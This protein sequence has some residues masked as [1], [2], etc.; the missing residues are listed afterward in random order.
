MSKTY[1]TNMTYRTNNAVKRIAATALLALT[2]FATVPALP[3]AAQDGDLLGT[4]YGRFTGLG[5]RDVRATAATIINILLSLL[6]IITLGY[7]IYAGFQWMTA[8]GNEEKAGEAR[9]TIY[10]AVIGL[11]IILTAY[12]ITNFVLKNQYRATTGY[13]YLD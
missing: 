4:E 10:S 6:G 12:G 13:Q 9:S 11:I 2:L 5:K 1:R 8:G 7:I 3:A